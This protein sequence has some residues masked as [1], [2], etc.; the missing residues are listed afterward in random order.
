MVEKVK[1]VGYPLPSEMFH[2]SEPK[3]E[4]VNFIKHQAISDLLDI[5]LKCPH[6]EEILLKADERRQQRTKK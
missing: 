3:K 2:D 6:C 1:H 5:D 4:P